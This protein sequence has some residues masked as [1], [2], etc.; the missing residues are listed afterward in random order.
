MGHL[1]DGEWRNEWYESAEDGS[2]H[3]P[4]TRFRE[5]V[6]RAE[7]SR[8][9]PESGRYHLYVSYACPWAHRTLIARRVKRLEDHISLSIV[10]PRMGD[11]GWEFSDYPGSIPDPVNGARYLRDVYLAADP[12]YTGRVTTPVL[13]DKQ[14]GT[15]VNNES[16][17]ILRMLDTEFD[18]LAASEVTLLPP[19]LA[20]SVD[21]TLDALYAPVNNGV[22]RA[23]FA[24]KQRAYEK[25]CRELFAALD[26]WEDVL[27]GQPYLCGDALTEADVAFYVT[28][29]RFDLVYYGHF[30]CNLRRIEDYPNL[31][32]YLKALYQTPSFT[33]TTNFDHIKTHYY[34]SQTTVNP[35][36]IV[37]LGPPIALDAPHDRDR[38]E[39]NT[40]WGYRSRSKPTNHRRAPAVAD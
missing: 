8:F 39:L 17:Q 21:E 20:R 30:K 9:R 4:E 19:S 29:V 5:W 40:P 32:N 36:R 37:P 24:T 1:K 2:F 14:E 26:H 28:L 18:D 6:T 25:A 31:F 22:Y 15:I 13:W 35:H 10:D 34:W 27:S 33:E 16:R 11:D 23:G 7:G 38:F 3:R 12:H